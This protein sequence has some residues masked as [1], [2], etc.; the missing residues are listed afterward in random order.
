MTYPAP[1][2]RRRMIGFGAACLFGVSTLAITASVAAAAEPG[3][4]D[5]KEIRIESD[6]LL[7]SGDATDR[8]IVLLGDPMAKVLPVPDEPPEV[9]ELTRQIELDVA[10]LTGPDVLGPIIA[11]HE[12]EDWEELAALGE[13]LGQLHAGM[14]DETI[15]ETVMEKDGKRVVKR[16]IVGGKDMTPE[17]REAF[18]A[19]IEAK[20]AALEAKMAARE[21][22]IG[23]HEKAI[24]HKMERIE[25][26]IEANSEEIERIMEERFGADFEAKVEAQAELIEYLVESCE[27]A[28]LNKGETRIIERADTQGEVFRLAC[29]EGD[30]ANLKAAATLAAVDSHPGI[31][32]AEKAAFKAAAEG[33]KR[34]HVMVIRGDKSE[35]A[36]PPAPPAPP[37]APLKGE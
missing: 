29:I 33:Q 28:E 36:E 20:A 21:A 10:E 8:Q 23:D 37:E 30:R 15:E 12:G 18:E 34:K 9:A 5:S 11:F 35:M 27:D 31:T 22:A 14:Y 13:E 17:Q 16:V 4:K 7:I 1:S 3:D 32:A 19:K 26:R 2:S 24:E 25:K 6:S